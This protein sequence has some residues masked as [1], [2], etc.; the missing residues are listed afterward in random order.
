MRA[1]IR[2]KSCLLLVLPL[3]AVSLRA[4]GAQNPVPPAPK[5]QPIPRA[6][7]A[8]D[9]SYLRSNAPPGGC[10][11]FN[12]NGGG[13]TFAWM[14]KPRKFAL[15]GDVTVAHAGS[16]SSN[17]YSLTLSTF[18]VGGRYLPHLSHS[19]LQPFGQVL[20]GVAFAS[21][22][23]AKATTAGTS[24]GAEAFAANAGGGVDLR[25]DH[26]F[27]IRLVEADYLAT[28]FNNGGNNHQNML[29]ISSGLVVRFGER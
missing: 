21:G 10:G 25:I 26:R 3:V 18:T 20:A 11:C 19:K 4:A 15:V 27:S 17:G 14:V 24:A 16:I 23:L 13:A 28:T 29:R 9:Y 12:M 6:E 22:S 2:I 5:A 8:V 7:L 1:I